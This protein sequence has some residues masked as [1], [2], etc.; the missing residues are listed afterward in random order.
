MGSASRV[1]AWQ[2][3]SMSAALNRRH[4]SSGKRRCSPSSRSDRW[5]I[6]GRAVRCRRDFLEGSS[7]GASRTTS[8]ARGRGSTSQRAGRDRI[9]EECPPDHGEP[10]FEGPS[11]RWRDSIFRFDTA[12]AHGPIDFPYPGPLR[13]RSRCFRIRRSYSRDQRPRDRFVGVEPSTNCSSLASRRRAL[14][15]R[16]TVRSDANAKF[17]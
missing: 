6:V 1:R 7:A 8:G 14:R 16:L 9:D 15:P 10:R 2:R 5:S 12:L 17:T 3:V 11:F 4:Q 13:S